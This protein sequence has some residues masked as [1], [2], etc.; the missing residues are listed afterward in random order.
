MKVWGPSLIGEGYLGH[1]VALRPS[2]LAS[3]SVD[4]GCVVSSVVLTFSF[5]CGCPGMRVKIWA[6]KLECRWVHF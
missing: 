1:D 2:A 3:T 5:Y 4:R 6:S